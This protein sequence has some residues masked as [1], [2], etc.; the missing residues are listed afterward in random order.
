MKT[1][2]SALSILILAVA[3]NKEPVAEFQEKQQ[4]VN[5]EYREEVNEANE[6]RIKKMHDAREDLREQQKEE[7]VEYVED[8][9]AATVNPNSDTIRIIKKEKQEE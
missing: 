7:A 2:L 4:E 5:K 9:E 8:S 6:E 1:L 3:C